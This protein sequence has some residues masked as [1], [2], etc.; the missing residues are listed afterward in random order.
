[1]LMLFGS[2]SN[3]TAFLIGNLAA[4]VPDCG[5]S[6]VA[7]APAARNVRRFMFTP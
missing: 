7:A 6:H 2:I 3:S 1:M 5:R 4:A